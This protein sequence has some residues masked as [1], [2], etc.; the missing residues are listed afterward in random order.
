M[1]PVYVVFGMDMRPVTAFTRKIDAE[2]YAENLHGEF[3]W[4]GAVLLVDVDTEIGFVRK[5]IWSVYIDLIHQ[6]AEPGIG[7]LSWRMVHPDDVGWIHVGEA[8][9]VAY[10]TISGEHAKEM[11]EHYLAG[12]YRGPLFPPEE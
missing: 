11:A 4:P 9:A 6:K 3:L 5:S 7:I 1:D 10:S 8:G 12:T 2:R